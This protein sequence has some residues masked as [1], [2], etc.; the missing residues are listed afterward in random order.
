MAIECPPCFVC[1]KTEWVAVY[2]EA[3]PEQAVCLECCQG[4]THADGHKGHDWK[5]DPGERDY[6][7]ERC[8]QLSRYTDETP[9][10]FDD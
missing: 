6:V 3:H 5:H 9:G 4:A 10:R 8:G 7:C 2:D 1:G